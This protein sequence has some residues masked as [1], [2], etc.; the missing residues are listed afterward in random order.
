M[1]T[2][3]PA[4]ELVALNIAFEQAEPDEI[5]RWALE[6]T[7]IER[8]AV[9]SAFQAEGTVVMHLATQIRPDVP[10]LFLETGYQFA[11]TLAFKEQ[12]T[13]QLALNVVDLVGEYTVEG[14][15]AAIGPR[16]FESDP[17]RCCDLNKVQPM[18][19]S[20]RNFDAWVTALRR[21]SSPT[22]A[23]APFVDQYEIE[24]GRWMIKVNPMATWTHQQVWRY[25]KEHDLPH[26]PLYDLGYSSIGCA[27]CTRMRFAG[28]PERAGRWAGKPKW[29]CG[30]HTADA[31]PATG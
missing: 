8:I 30:I 14:Q 23:T 6:S 18:L 7:G 10:I 9:A 28:E 1:H 25:L 31:T 4:D 19:E 13:E 27:P 17:E 29:E 3:L 24:P 21:D 16:L 26:N 15:A 20:L 11:E 2:L 12:L 22:R 5:L